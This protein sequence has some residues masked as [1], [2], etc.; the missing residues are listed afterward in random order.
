MF[1]FK[2]EGNILL[3]QTKK[4]KLKKEKK[5]KFGRNFQYRRTPESYPPF[6][7]SGYASRFKKK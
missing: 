4:N 5:I 3:L 1:P 2:D 6:N 7:D